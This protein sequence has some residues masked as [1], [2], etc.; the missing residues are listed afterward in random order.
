MKL[1]F[2]GIC[3]Y[4]VNTYVCDVIFSLIFPSLFTVKFSSGFN[5]YRL[6]F[7]QSFVVLLKIGYWNS[8]CNEIKMNCFLFSVCMSAQCIH[9]MMQQYTSSNLYYIVITNKIMNAI[10]HTPTKNHMKRNCTC[11]SSFITIASFARSY[12]KY[13]WRK[14][15]MCTL[16]A[17]ANQK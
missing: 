2:L 5:V 13:T 10:A 12:Y 15:T 8:L 11:L 17:V 7:L 6:F 14:Q 9:V 1:S 4:I 16:E 3:K